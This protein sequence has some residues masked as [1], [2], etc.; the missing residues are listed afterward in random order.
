MPAG[1]IKAQR[2]GAF[3]GEM[4]D[5]NGSDC[6]GAE[7]AYPV[8]LQDCDQFVALHAMQVVP[9]LRRR[10]LE[11]NVEICPHLIADYLLLKQGGWPELQ[12]ATVERHAE[13]RRVYSG[14][15]TSL[16]ESILNDGNRILERVQLLNFFVGDQQCH[17]Y[18]C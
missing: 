6:A 4:F 7:P 17:S 10:I 2:I 13:A 14:P 1:A 5:R 9:A 16:P 18:P 3:R 11:M 8:G 15:F 12:E